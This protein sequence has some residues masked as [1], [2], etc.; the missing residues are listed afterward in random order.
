[1][2]ETCRSYPH[3]ILVPPPSE[4]LPWTD[5]RIR[6]RSK[7]PPYRLS[8]ILHSYCLTSTEHTDSGVLCSMLLPFLYTSFQL[9][10]HSRILDA[11]VW[12]Y[13]IFML[14]IC[15]N[16]TCSSVYTALYCLLHHRTLNLLLKINGLLKRRHHGKYTYTHVDFPAGCSEQIPKR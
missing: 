15:C 4:P 6:H 1:M 10:E 14:M 7:Q 3:L 2:Y 8:C 13:V 16:V 11:D 9:K 5:K 12:T